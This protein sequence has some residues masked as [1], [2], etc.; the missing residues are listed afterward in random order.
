MPT[1]IANMMGVRN[2]IRDRK[3][4]EQLKADL[5]EHLWNK[6]GQGKTTTEFRM[7]LSNY[8]RLFT[9]LCFYVFC[10]LYF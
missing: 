9:N 8:Y 7:F 4:H 10:N 5:I 3:M 2:S 1:N 6:Y